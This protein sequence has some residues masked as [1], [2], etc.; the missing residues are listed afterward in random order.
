M[1]AWL[2]RSVSQ[3]NCLHDLFWWYASS[4]EPKSENAEMKHVSLKGIQFVYISFILEFK[5]CILMK[6]GLDNGLWRI[7]SHPLSES[8]AA[9]FPLL[10]E[11]F[12]LLL[13]TMADIMPHLPIGSPLLEMAVKCWGVSFSRK[14]HRFLHKLVF[15][16]FITSNF[17]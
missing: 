2:L 1:L 14:D 3:P 13:Q 8:P 16:C 6:E 9:I 17:Y 4:L 15:K 11:S 10:S 5:L 7:R 12:Y